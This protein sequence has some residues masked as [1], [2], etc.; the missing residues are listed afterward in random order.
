LRILLN[1][2]NT[3]SLKK[4]VLKI[5]SFYC[6]ITSFYCNIC[7]KMTLFFKLIFWDFLYLK[8][9]RECAIFI[10]H[11]I[12]NVPLNATDEVMSISIEWPNF[13]TVDVQLGAISATMH[14]F[15]WNLAVYKRSDCTLISKNCVKIQ[16]KLAEIYK[17]NKCPFFS[18]HGE[19]FRTFGHDCIYIYIYTKPCKSFASLA[20]IHR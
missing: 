19:W 3:K 18:Q 1:T 12:A 8:Y 11:L 17:K 4:L 9:S 7:S 2:L 14:G 16:Q 13:L 10:H 20:K 5:T 15:A 6:I